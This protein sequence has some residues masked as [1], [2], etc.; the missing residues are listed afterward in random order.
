MA[1]AATVAVVV[2]ISLI[3]A[4]IFLKKQSTLFTKG[5]PTLKTLKVYISENIR[6]DYHSE[7][8]FIAERYDFFQTTEIIERAD[9][10]LSNQNRELVI[11]MPNGERIYHQFIGN[12]QQFASEVVAQM[13]IYLA[14]NYNDSTK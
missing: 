6:A 12:T 10:I 1:L 11:I 5:R 7:L 14:E 8:T 4:I 3:V 2:L 9:I 13:A